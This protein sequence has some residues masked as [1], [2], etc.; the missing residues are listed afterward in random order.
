MC[1]RK[2]PGSELRPPSRPTSPELSS[3]TSSGEWPEFSSSSPSASSASY[4]SKMPKE[5]ICVYF[6]E[7]EEENV[8]RANAAPETKAMDLVGCPRCFMYVMLSE[9]DPKCPK[10]KSTVFLEFFKAENFKTDN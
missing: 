10:C 2:S 8:Q 7:A 1:K 4:T 5:G 6:P 3:S 9:A